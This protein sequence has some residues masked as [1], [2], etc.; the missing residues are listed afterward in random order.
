MEGPAA[1]LDEAR[2]YLL[3]WTRNVDQRDAIWGVLMGDLNMCQAAAMCKMHRATIARKIEELRA[4]PAF[5]AMVRE[6]HD[7]ATPEAV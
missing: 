7:G 1:N 4:D 3:G 6:A 5:G 2:A